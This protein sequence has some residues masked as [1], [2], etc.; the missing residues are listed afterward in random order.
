[1]NSGLQL[2]FE[3]VGE[4]GIVVELLGHQ[5]FVQDGAWCPH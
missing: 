1:M 5:D 3:Q 2:V 4:V